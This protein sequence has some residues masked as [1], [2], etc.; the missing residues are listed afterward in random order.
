MHKQNWQVPIKSGL[1]DVLNTD[2]VTQAIIDVE[3]L[4]EHW[5][6]RYDADAYTLGATLYEDIKPLGGIYN[7]MEIVKDS[8]PILIKQFKWL[9]DIVISKLSEEIGPAQLDGKLGY[10]GFHIFGHPPNKLNSDITLQ[11]MQTPIAAIH[12]DRQYNDLLPYW[13]SCFLQNYDLSMPISFTLALELP[14]NGGGLS[15]WGTNKYEIDDEYSTYVKSLDY[16]NHEQG[17]LG[18][19]NIVPYSLGKMFYF[20]GDMLHQIAPAYNMSYNDR[21]ITMQGHGIKCNGIW[22]IYF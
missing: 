16:S 6:K 3:Q 18:P 11:V 4:Y 20:I 21:R 5:V 13:N 17:H 7:Y 14:K 22:R 10:P 12:Y 19:P 2:E 8:N 1:I 15:T 9:Y